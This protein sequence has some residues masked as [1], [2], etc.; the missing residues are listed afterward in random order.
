MEK[1]VNLSDKE[2]E[3]KAKEHDWYHKSMLIGIVL[4]VV[5]AMGLLVSGIVVMAM[6]TG[7]W[8]IIFGLP[9]IVFG[10]VFMIYTYDE[11]L[12]KNFTLHSKDDDS[13]ED[14]E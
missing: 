11:V 5:V 13:D 9:M 2:A 12:S 7:V 8:G 14:V 4:R 1:S 6:R 3:F 10:S